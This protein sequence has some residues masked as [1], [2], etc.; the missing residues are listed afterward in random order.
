V[1]RTDPNGFLEAADN[2]TYKVLVAYMAPISNPVR[3]LGLTLPLTSPMFTCQL[4]QSTELLRNEHKSVQIPD[5]PVTALSACSGKM[6]QWKQHFRVGE[7]W[8]Y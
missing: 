2:G 4:I 6:G 8:S 1:A 5:L 3:V 7:F